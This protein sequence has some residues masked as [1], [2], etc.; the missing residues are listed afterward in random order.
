MHIYQIELT[1]YCNSQCPWCNHSRMKRNKGFMDWRTFERTI[2]FLKYAPPP[3]NTVGLHHFGESLLHPEIDSYL[4]YLD[5]HN[6]NW[7]L[8]TNGRLLKKPELREMLLK[9]K[10][11]LV[12]SMDNGA[13]LLSVNTLIQEKSQ[14]R[15]ELQ[16]LI[17]TFG[18]ANLD[19]LLPGQYEIYHTAKHS[20]GSNGTGEYTKCCFLNQNWACVLWDGTIVSC[21]FDLEGEAKIGHVKHQN[22]FVSAKWRLCPTCEVVLRC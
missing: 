19:G 17:Q 15:S 13:D 14:K 4:K 5:N 8:S 1:N 11:L 7:R 16:I 20:W 12:I 22:A 6:V 21:C 3:G 18:T 9:Y 10:G 2:E